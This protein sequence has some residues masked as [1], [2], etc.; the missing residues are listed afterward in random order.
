MLLDLNFF[1][2]TPA[3]PD[4]AQAIVRALIAASMFGWITL[5]GVPQHSG[6]AAQNFLLALLFTSTYAIASSLDCLELA[7]IKKIHPRFRR[8]A[9]LMAEPLL[10]GAIFF[11]GGRI[12]IQFIF[13]VL[14]IPL[15]TGFR[16]GARHCY[17]S[18]ASFI[19]I[20]ITLIFT[21]PYWHDHG[22]LGA[23]LIL[24]AL[25]LG[26]YSVTLA[27]RLNASNKKLAD[28]ATQDPLTGLPNRCLFMEYLEHA[29]ALCSRNG[30]YCACV[31]FDLDGF[32]Y[33]NDTY[34]HATGDLLLIEV[35]KKITV[36]L[37]S[38]DIVARWGGDEFSLIVECLAVPSDA[39]MVAQKLLTALGTITEVR[40][41]PV[42]ISASIGIAWCGGQ[43][44][45][46]S[47]ITEDELIKNADHAMYE[48]KNGGKGRIKISRQEG[49]ILPQSN[50]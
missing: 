7:T 45:A 9:W 19:V 3:T 38:T 30:K 39:V 25:M 35:S 47:G 31:F 10:I 46:N 1:H 42:T 14:L 11:V 2:K 27:G 28:M 15:D 36:C 40:G 43:E 20:L 24:T 4:M 5:V 48:A 26:A 12:S 17:V 37:R 50:A 6:L 22:W 41:H 13:V 49:F 16:F 23:G 21:N 33:V 18:V 44:N 8:S 32:K 29:M 34:G